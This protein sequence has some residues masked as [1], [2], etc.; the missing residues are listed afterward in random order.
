MDILF[1]NDSTKGGNYAIA[2]IKK[3]KKNQSQM[4]VAI[5]L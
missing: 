2:D 4:Q 3:A 5:N 1:F